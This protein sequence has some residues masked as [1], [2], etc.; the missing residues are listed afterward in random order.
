M[1]R[2]VRQTLQLYFLPLTALVLALAWLGHAPALTQLE[3]A[4]F[5]LC[6][7]T[8]LA[9][10]CQ[11]P[12]LAAAWSLFTIV[13]VLTLL[14]ASLLASGVV[15]RYAR[16]LQLELL[17]VQKGQRDRLGDQIP[18]ELQGLAQQINRAFPVRQAAGEP[19]IPDLIHAP[20]VPSQPP[21][22]RKQAAD[23]DESTLPVYTRKKAPRPPETSLKAEPRPFPA[24]QEASGKAPGPGSREPQEHQP[25][26]LKKGETATLTAGKSSRPVQQM[27]KHLESFRQRYPGKHFE[28]IT[29]LEDDFSWPTRAADLDEILANLLDNAGRWAHAQID[30]YLASK[31]NVLAL[32]VVDDGPGVNTDQVSQLG[33]PGLT[34]SSASAGK[35]L[36]LATVRYIIGQYGGGLAFSISRLGGLEVLATLPATRPALHQLGDS[37]RPGK[38]PESR[39]H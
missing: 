35:G 37:L 23:P 14:A 18:D 7:G 2:S 36:G 28:L 33:T 3:Q 24:D 22:R 16:N 39:L 26:P 5:S 17:A 31:S 34:L 29:E 38:D 20:P 30:I 10:P 15:R 4:W 13:L 1:H 12:G 11:H 32:E 27:R 19:I 9:G 25:A 6:S 21:R 8:A